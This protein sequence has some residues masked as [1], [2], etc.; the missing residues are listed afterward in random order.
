LLLLLVGCG[1]DTSDAPLAPDTSPAVGQRYRFSVA[2]PK[3]EQVLTITHVG[4]AKLRYS[5]QNVVDDAVVGE[6]P[7]RALELVFASRPQAK[8]LKTET[9]TLAGRTYTCQVKEDG[10]LRAYT[11]V[12]DGHE[13]FPGVVRISDGEDVVFELRA[14]EAPKSN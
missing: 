3:A 5:V 12:K 9:L 8:D 11:A 6:H 7:E 1:G 10:K 4:K 2:A 14:V 13:R